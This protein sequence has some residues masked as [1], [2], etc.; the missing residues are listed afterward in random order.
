[1]PLSA[2]KP[3]PEW[4][5]LRTVARETHRLTLR[6]NLPLR[7]PAPL[8]ELFNEERAVQKQRQI[9]NMGLL[10]IL[11]FDMFLVGD[12]LVAPE[13]VGLAMF[14]RLGVVTPVV[15]AALWLLW[16]RPVSAI[17]QDLFSLSYCILC[18]LA[19]LH[20][21]HFSFASATIQAGLETLLLLVVMNT[22]LRPDLWAA[23]LGTVVCCGMFFGF[24]VLTHMFTRAEQWTLAGQVFWCATLTL[25][26]NNRLLREQRFS[27][28]LQVRGRIQRQSLTEENRE[29]LSLS[30]QDHLTGIPNR[31]AYERRLTELWSRVV[32]TG[33][34]IAVV[35]V[36]VDYFKQVNDSF[37]H[38][39][40]DR[41]LQRIAKLLEQSMRAELDFVARYGGEE[42][43]VLLPGSNLESGVQVAERIRVLVQVAG[44]P[45]VTR[46]DAP[47]PMD[48]K[49][50]TVSCGVA[51]IQPGPTDDPKSLV[52]AADAALYLAKQTGRNRVCT[53]GALT[54]VQRA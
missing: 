5:D 23:A 22:M 31:A 12:Y 6:G 3:V 47:L 24:L 50:S 10:A 9:V 2:L 14:V 52:D 36:D 26:A 51:A 15:L 21:H 42:F 17:T 41:V 54:L 27:W 1:M 45:A 44:S 37:G 4:L 25:L 43:V 13:Q 32:E 7:F 29:L 48:V 16:K 39:Y 20:L 53:P 35:M 11:V 33:E 46:G 38:L 8:E 30:L 34:W 28:L 19:T 40:G 18:C 49:W